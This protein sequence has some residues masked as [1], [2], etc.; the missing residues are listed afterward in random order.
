MKH[1]KPLLASLLAC[2][3]VTSLVLTGCSTKQPSSA[4]GLSEMPNSSG[5]S[6]DSE[7]KESAKDPGQWGESATT[8][9]ANASRKV[10]FTY[11]YQ[12]ETTTM[13]VTLAALETA[14]Q[15][16]GGY[17][18]NANYSGRKAG[19]QYAYATLT[20]RIPTAS[21]AAFRKTIEANGNV[22]AKSEEGRD[23]TDEYYD[24]EARLTVLYSQEE[25]LLDLLG[26][27]GALSD[28]LE[29]ERELNRV[30]TEIERLTGTLKKYDGLVDYATFTIE[31]YNVSEY[32]IEPPEEETFFEQ[33]K[34]SFID[35]MEIALD[36][37]QGLLIALVYI[38]PYAVVIGLVVFICIRIARARR[39]K[40]PAK[41]PRPKQPK[42]APPVPAAYY[43]PVPPPGSYASQGGY[44]PPGFY[45]DP[46]D[47]EPQDQNPQ[48][49]EPGDPDPTPDNNDVSEKSQGSIK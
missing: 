45:P 42:Y 39:R 15:A 48:N 32:T 38:L 14:I 4:G 29:I 27:R 36:V 46:Q 2:L 41:P 25:R 6:Y 47:P 23:I 13:D 49:Q 28:L 21:V 34:R 12:L 31:I 19:D 8:I 3:L 37:L 40:N 20:C 22:R 10:I 43:A 33:L 26:Q 35:S 44:A 9:S 1:L 16:S 30:R 24:V 11:K 17:I 5:P 18:E 7:L